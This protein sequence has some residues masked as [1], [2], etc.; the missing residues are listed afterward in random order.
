[1]RRNRDGLVSDQKIPLFPPFRLRCSEEKCEEYRFV[2][3][4]QADLWMPAMLDDGWLFDAGVH[5]WF[6]PMHAFLVHPTKLP[7]TL[8]NVSAVAK[9]HVRQVAAGEK[10]RAKDPGPSDMGPKPV[11]GSVYVGRKRDMIIDVEIETDI[12]AAREVVN[13]LNTARR[14]PGRFAVAKIEV[15]E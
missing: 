1:M 2:G 8:S 3:N 10:P 14:L 12:E 9:E 4:N 6:C 13:D 11:Y 15:I 7:L 5:L